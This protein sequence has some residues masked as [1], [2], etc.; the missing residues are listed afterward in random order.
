MADHNDLGLWGEQVAREYL[1]AR[2]YAVAGENTRYGGV[3]IDFIAMRDDII[4]FVEVK[5]RRT[6][7]VDPL[8][9]VDRRKRARLVRAAD[10]YMR[11]FAIPLQP[12]FDIILVIGTPEKYRI[13]H[14]PDAFFPGMM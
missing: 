11:D 14:I 3:E 6:D 5:T 4:C 7:Y 2:G 12:Q 8:E 9:A 1:I 10:A 13:E